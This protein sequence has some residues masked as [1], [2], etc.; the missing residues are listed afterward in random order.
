MI[1]HNPD[2]VDE[3]VNAIVREIHPEKVYLFGSYARGEV[4]AD[5]DVDLLIVQAE[6]FGPDRSRWKEL[7]R[8]RKLLTSC[9]V[10]K[11]ILVYSRSEVEKWGRSLNHIISY[12]V[13]E[14]RL[15]YER[16]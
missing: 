3:M 9:R 1:Q 11:D 14:G 10:P 12:A 7:Q 13:R 15:L 6:D 16:S 8:I 4:H 2:V 5:S